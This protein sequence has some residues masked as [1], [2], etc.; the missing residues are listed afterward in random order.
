MPGYSEKEAN[1]IFQEW[2]SE[3]EKPVVPRVMVG[4]SNVDP[5]RKDKSL[6]EARVREIAREEGGSGCDCPG[7]AT[8]AEFDEM[9]TVVGLK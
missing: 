8:N 7:M 9:L 5:D 4:F 6:T 1:Q 3:F 2:D